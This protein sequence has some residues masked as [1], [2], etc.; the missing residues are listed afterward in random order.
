MSTLTDYFDRAYVINLPE[1]K[2]SAK[3][4]ATAWGGPADYI[5]ETRGILVAP[6]NIQAIINGFA[7][8]M[9]RLIDFP[10]VQQELGECGRRRVEE[11]FDWDKKIDRML[12]VYRH[13]RGTTEEK[14]GE[15]GLAARLAGWNPAARP[16]HR[17]KRRR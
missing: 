10:A 1:R 3:G 17:G 2:R 13:A 11:Q 7:A 6:S 14:P 12:Q 5:D 9:Q 8:G 15:C 16:G 4:I